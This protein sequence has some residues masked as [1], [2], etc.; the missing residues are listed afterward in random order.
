MIVFKDFFDI[1]IIYLQPSAKTQFPG[2]Y[3]LCFAPLGIVRTAGPEATNSQ[4]N[5]VPREFNVVYLWYLVYSHTRDL[6]VFC[7]L[8]ANI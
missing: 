7:I 6:L 5:M 4:S 8:I 2:G 3:L 1:S